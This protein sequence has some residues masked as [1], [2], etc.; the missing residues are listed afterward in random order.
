MRVDVFE[1]LFHLLE[2][3]LNA[4]CHSIN[5][6]YNRRIY[7]IVYSIKRR[8]IYFIN[9]INYTKYQEFNK[10]LSSSHSSLSFSYLIFLFLVA[11]CYIKD[12]HTAIHK[13]PNITT[14]KVIV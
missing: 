5:Y 14:V 1:F 13:Y 12:L 3:S 7:M 11:S 6:L 9:Y 4:A 8:L 10:I 2:V